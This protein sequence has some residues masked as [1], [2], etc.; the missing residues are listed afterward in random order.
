MKLLAK[1]N[2]IFLSVLG[3][4]LGV[5]ILLASNFLREQAKA[6]VLQ[7]ASLMMQ[8]TLATRAYTTEQIKPL[9]KADQRYRDRFLPQQVPAYAATE[10]FN[11]LHKR[12]SDYAYKEATLNP[13]NLRDRA[14]DWEADVINRF[15]NKPDQKEYVGERNTPDGS[16]SLFLARPIRIQD[17]ACLECH[18]VPSRAPISM[19]HQYGPNNGFGWLPNEIIGAQVVSVPMSVPFQIADKALR[20]LTIYLVILGLLALGIL[21]LV[22]IATVIRPVA[23]LSRMADDISQGRLHVEELA[24]TGRDEISVLALAFNRM[25]RS[26]SSAMKMLESEDEDETGRH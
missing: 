4:G 8:T 26:L 2:L 6:Q 20:T 23:K 12:Y 21:D 3:L 17:P 1:F 24:V 16:R 9:L 10:M 11:N 14:T 13:T 22:L 19:V 5:A 7:Q 18:S 25:Q 15:R